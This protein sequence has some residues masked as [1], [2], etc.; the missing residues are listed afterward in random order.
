MRIPTI[1]NLANWCPSRIAVVSTVPR[2]LARLRHFSVLSTLAVFVVVSAACSDSSG[3]GTADLTPAATMSENGSPTGDATVQATATNAPPATATP[4]V[5]STPEPTVRQTPSFQ[6]GRGRVFALEFLGSVTPRLVAVE[7]EGHDGFDRL[8]FQFT[9]SL[10]GY[11]V[12]YFAS[13]LSDCRTGK[14]VQIPGA[15]FLQIQMA[16][17]LVYDDDLKPILRP[18]EF[19]SNLAPLLAGRERCDREE[20]LVWMVGLSEEVDFRVLERTDPFRLII[21]VA[22]P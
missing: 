17:V 11:V 13:S 16:P 19:Q 2:R 22:H 21:D 4:V 6:G 12:E 9:A 3:T 18:M 7:T 20:I 10:P 8:V 15:A 5:T 14:P 1:K